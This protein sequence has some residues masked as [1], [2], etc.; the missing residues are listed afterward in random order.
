MLHSDE[1]CNEQRVLLYSTTTKSPRLSSN[2]WNEADTPGLRPLQSWLECVWLLS[3]WWSRKRKKTPFHF[4]TSSARL[5]LVRHL[6]LQQ[7]HTNI[8]QKKNQQCIIQKFGPAQMSK[9]ETSICCCLHQRETDRETESHLGQVFS[10]SACRY[11]AAKPS[12]EFCCTEAISLYFMRRCS[13]KMGWL[14]HVQVAKD[15]RQGCVWRS[16]P[17]ASCRARDRNA[18]PFG[19]FEWLMSRRLQKGI[20]RLHFTS[21]L[22]KINSDRFLSTNLTSNPG[23]LCIRQQKAHPRSK[24]NR[25]EIF[26]PLIWRTYVWVQ[27]PLPHRRQ[28]RTGISVVLVLHLKY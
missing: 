19:P 25:K 6:A 26:F 15:D 24:C 10:G 28:G 11:V 9:G 2:W 3:P 16:V 1:K 20:E 23:L 21:T 12:A 13:P 7:Q 5:R 27:W 8:H 18:E 22:I 17:G 14:L 4:P